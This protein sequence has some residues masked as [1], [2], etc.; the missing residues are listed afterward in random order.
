M[1]II[2]EQI[3]FAG[4]TFSQE[5]QQDYVQLGAKSLCMYTHAHHKHYAAA[6]MSPIACKQTRA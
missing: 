1:Y 6:A 5:T 3:L 4:A 2:F